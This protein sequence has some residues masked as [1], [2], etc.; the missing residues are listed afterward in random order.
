M[1]RAKPPA[2]RAAAQP[3]GEQAEARQSCQLRKDFAFK[4]P[5]KG[6]SRARIEFIRKKLD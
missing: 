2:E 6:M 4:V 3:V 1:V 5:D